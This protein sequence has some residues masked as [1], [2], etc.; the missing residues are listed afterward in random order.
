MKYLISSLII[1]VTVLIGGIIINTQ[2]E[3]EPETDRDVQVRETVTNN[4]KN[5]YNRNPMRR[6]SYDEGQ[7]TH[8]VFDK[9]KE[10]GNMIER[11]WRD[12]EHWAERAEDDG[13]TV[14][15]IPEEGTILQTSEE[16]PIGHVAYV[17]NIHDDGSIQI[18]EMNLHDPYEITERTISDEELNNYAYI[19]PKE[20]PHEESEENVG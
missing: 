20:N 10:D 6:N 3:E 13:Y 17:E 9:V 11:I 14:S 16:G 19:H 7:C 8:Y 4:E 1:I 5:N 12:A 2:F 15:D 18:S